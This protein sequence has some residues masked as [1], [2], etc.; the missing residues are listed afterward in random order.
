MIEERKFE[1]LIETA[2]EYIENYP[3]RLEGFIFVCSQIQK[4][5]KVMKKFENLGLMLCALL[6]TFSACKEKEKNDAYVKVQKL[7]GITPSANKELQDVE[8]KFNDRKLLWTHTDRF[9]K[10]H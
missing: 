8:V 4:Q 10:L 2:R 5:A 6:I 9:I 7:M 3:F 1:I